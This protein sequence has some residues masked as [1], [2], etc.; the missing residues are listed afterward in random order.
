MWF[1]S[2]WSFLK[3]WEHCFW[4]FLKLLLVFSLVLAPKAGVF[5][6]FFICLHYFFFFFFTFSEAW[7]DCWLSS[8]LAG[9][10]AFGWVFLGYSYYSLLINFSGHL[11]Q[12]QRWFS[13][14]L[15]GACILA[16]VS[17]F[18]DFLTKLSQQS[19]S[20]L[21]S[22]IQSLIDGLRFL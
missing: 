17:S 7:L 19:Y 20:Q 6:S 14:R 16:L 9:V 10:V 3:P 5:K 18:I 11:P 15:L 2:F 13:S 4:F 12:R 22:C 21:S 8:S 1:R